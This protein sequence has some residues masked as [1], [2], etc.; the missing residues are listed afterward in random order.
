MNES[1][2]F[3]VKDEPNRPI[4][5]ALKESL[6]GLEITFGETLP[7][8]KRDIAKTATGRETSVVG[9]LESY[10]P[11]DWSVKKGPIYDQHGNVS[12]E[13]DCAIC[14]PQHPPCRTPRRDL[15]L[16]EGVHSAVEVKPD[17]SSLGEK[18]EF[19]RSLRQCYSVKLLKRELNLVIK[20]MKP[21]P[22]GSH[23][24]PYVVFADKISDLKSSARFMDEQ[25]GKNGWGAWDLPDI[26]L[27]LKEGII[28][29]AADSARCSMSGWFSKKPEISSSGE[30]YL[31]FHSRDETL[32]CF[33]ALLFSYASPQPQLSPMI[34]R[35]YI[36]PIKLPE[37]ELMVVTD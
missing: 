8:F 35:D 14:V 16:A 22:E 37:M 28:Y 20:P 12:R 21:L 18:G 10:F 4:Y 26:V 17:I 33:L 30:K 5:D 6:A 19:E 31:I 1:P 25:K 2:E 23:R 34:L 13:V 27:G 36:F 11:S 29:H 7:S 15:I 3:V 32:I 9:F 24:I